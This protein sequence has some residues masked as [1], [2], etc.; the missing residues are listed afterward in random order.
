MMEFS[1]LWFHRRVVSKGSKWKLS[2]VFVHVVEGRDF[3]LRWDDLKIA[4][5]SDR[6][7]EQKNFWI[8]QEFT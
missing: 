2:I 6:I 3:N 8:L 5:A 7:V 4:G 1:W